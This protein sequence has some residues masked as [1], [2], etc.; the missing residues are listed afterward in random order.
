MTK[1][2]QIGKVITG[3]STG[4]YNNSLSGFRNKIINPD[5]EITQRGGS[6]P[7]AI[8]TGAGSYTLDRWRYAGSNTFGN[9]VTIS[10]L[11]MP[12]GYNG[13]P[14]Y[15]RYYA[16]LNRT[17]TGTGLTA[18][19]QRIEG[20]RTLAGKR[21][22]LTFWV[23]GTN[24]KIIKT[25]IQQVFGTGTPTPS[26]VVEVVSAGISATL[27]STF[28]R[29]D[30]VFDMPSIDSASVYGADDRVEVSFILYE[31]QGNAQF[32]IA[33]VS[34]VEGDARNDP[35]PCAPRDLGTELD[36]CK[37]YYQRIDVDGSVWLL[38]QT[39]IATSTR[40]YVLLDFE[41]EFRVRPSVAYIG[42]SASYF[43]GVS[44]QYTTTQ[45]VAIQGPMRVQF[46]VTVP[47]IQPPGNAGA[48]C[49]LINFNKIGGGVGY[50][51]GHAEL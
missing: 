35:D 1:A 40:A 6:F 16:R 30:V 17:T 27:T 4:Q 22:T 28:T 45:V 38:G 50:I 7:F 31:N 14:G 24:D 41:K 2:F 43:D 33:H 21:S 3:L 29:Y 20:V 18:L 26:P 32:D 44:W 15:V 5:F 13:I 37:R 19:Q 39:S 51:E 49:W 9:A 12:S 10:Q 36:L 11:A 34:L 42:G 48:T 8:N 47:A 23:R 25:Q 46:S